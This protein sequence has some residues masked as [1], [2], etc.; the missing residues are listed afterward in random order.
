M[1]PSAMFRLAD[2]KTVGNVR[3]LLTAKIDAYF[4]KAHWDMLMDIA[5]AV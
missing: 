3:P 5:A 2:P 4:V 1:L